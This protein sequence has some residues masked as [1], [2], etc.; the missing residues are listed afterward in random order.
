MITNKF[1]KKAYDTVADALPFAIDP[2]KIRVEPGLS[3]CISPIKVHDYAVGVMA[4]FGSAV[5]YLGRLRGL[6]AQTMKLNRRRSGLL[7]NS[8]QMH[9]LN[10]YGTIF[11]SWPI[12][13]DNGTYRT[14]DGRYVTMIGFHPHLRDGLLDYL[15]AANTAQAIQAAVEKKTAQQL[16]DETNARVLPL[17]M[18]RTP[19]EWRAHP[20]GEATAARP[21]IELA[22]NGDAQ[23]RRLGEAHYRPLE[24][25]R[26]VELTHVIAGPMAGKILAEQGA[27]VIKVQP[28]HGDWA[29]PVWLDVSWGKK[30]IFLDIKSPAGKKRFAELLASADVLLSSQR[31][32]ALVKLGFDAA[33]LRE[34]N[35]NLIFAEENCYVEAT[36][37]AG[38]RGFEQI[39]QAVTGVIDVHSKDLSEPTVTSV[40]MNDTLTAYLA[41]I[42]IVAALAEREEHG[43]FWKVGAS[44]TRTSMEALN[45]V[46][47]K[48]AEQYAPVTRQD[49]VE[50]AVDQDSPSGTFT[51]IGSAVEFSH[52]PSYAERPTSWPGT[53]PDTIGWT[54]VANFT[55]VNITHYPSK[56]AREGGIRNHIVSFGI[57]DR[58]DGGGVLGLA[59]KHQPKELEEYIEAH[60]REEAVEAQNV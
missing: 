22:Q 37:W 48:D 35:P 32:D 54:P 60:R 43:G 24:G 5:E 21:L 52:I 29:S 41:V 31:R 30:N 10:G 27:D 42:G 11:D 19:E 20:Q 38:R 39:A 58:G 46:E 15:Q 28:P 50:H 17:G 25:V 4:A 14:K 33:T 47:P 40:V 6:P 51:R 7:M 53:D 2:T 9:F 8:L 13:P 55:P 59:S 16:E 18:V 12:G 1:Q 44:L 57:E 3:Y 56:L 34:I 49:L 26:V 36:P 45:F 23:K